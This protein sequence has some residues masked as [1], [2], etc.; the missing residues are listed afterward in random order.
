[1]RSFTFS[2][3]ADRFDIISPKHN[4]MISYDINSSKLDETEKEEE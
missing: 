3:T 4:L 1:M 2:G